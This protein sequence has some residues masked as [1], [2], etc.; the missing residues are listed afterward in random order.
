MRYTKQSNGQQPAE[1]KPRI[2]EVARDCKADRAE[3]FLHSLF[4]ADKAE[5]QRVIVQ[6]DYEKGTIGGQGRYVIDT[7]TD[8]VD[9]IAHML[10]ELGAMDKRVRSLLPQIAR[11]GPLNGEMEA[12]E[13]PE[14]ERPYLCRIYVP[15]Q[16]L[17]AVMP[18]EVSP[19]R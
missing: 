3:T 9:E 12:V 5:A 19:E 18:C 7:W 11:S 8:R 4:A 15:E 6:V 16:L 17:A 10:K 2:A 13:H 14:K 1:P